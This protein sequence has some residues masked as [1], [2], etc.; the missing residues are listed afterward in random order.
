METYSYFK[1]LK[2]RSDYFVLDSFPAPSPKPGSYFAMYVLSFELD[3]VNFSKNIR[4]SAETLVFFIV[5]GQTEHI[6]E[7]FLHNLLVAVV[8]ENIARS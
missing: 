3:L 8:V 1:Y 2:G 7:T 4:D 5:F 6:V